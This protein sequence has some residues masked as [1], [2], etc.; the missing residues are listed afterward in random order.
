MEEISKDLE[1]YIKCGQCQLFGESNS[2]MKHGVCPKTKQGED[3][4]YIDFE[5][6]NSARA[7]TPGDMTIAA[8]LLACSN[9]EIYVS[10]QK[11]SMTTSTHR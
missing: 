10:D 7:T 4:S 8:G 11:A 3:Y 1:T 5:G 2:L 9:C 6:S